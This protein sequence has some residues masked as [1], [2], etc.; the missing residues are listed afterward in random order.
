M[1]AEEY[2]EWKRRSIEF[3]ERYLEH[4]NSQVRTRFPD[5][6]PSETQGVLDEMAQSIEGDRKLLVGTEQGVAAMRP[7]ERA[8]FEKRM[9]SWEQESAPDDEMFAD[10]LRRLRDGSISMDDA[11]YW[12]Q[13]LQEQHNARRL[14]FHRLIDKQDG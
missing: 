9:A 1:T 4:L 5:G 13:S 12:Q 8:L 6:V 14:E 10:L 3:S 11:M 7:E 2:I